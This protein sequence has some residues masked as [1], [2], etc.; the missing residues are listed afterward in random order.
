MIDP[1]TLEPH[2]VIK[3]TQIDG[4][5]TYG[6]VTSTNDIFREVMV[7]SREHAVRIHWNDLRWKKAVHVGPW[8]AVSKEIA[9]QCFTAKLI[10]KKLGKYLNRKQRRQG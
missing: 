1:E 5:I 3:F 4:S 9:D 10:K 2:Q 6:V 7:R 8:S